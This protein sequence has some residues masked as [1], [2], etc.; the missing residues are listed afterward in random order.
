MYLTLSDLKLRL[1][2]T[3]NTRDVELQSLLDA[4]RSKIQAEW[5]DYISKPHKKITRAKNWL[6]WVQLDAPNVTSIEKVGWI[7]VNFVKDIDYFVKG[8]YDHIVRLW[9]VVN[10]SWNYW[11]EVEVSYTAW[12]ETIP[13]TLKDAQFYIVCAIKAIQLQAQNAFNGKMNIKEHTAW[14]RKVIYSDSNTGVSWA[15]TYTDLA[16]DIFLNVFNP[17]PLT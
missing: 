3:D 10:Y 13:D 15:S 6:D 7:D 11:S 9:P 14:Q 5:Y 1:W 4:S 8:Q 16:N 12:Y 2:I 17:I